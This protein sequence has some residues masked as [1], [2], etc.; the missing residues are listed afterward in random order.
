MYSV[1][2]PFRQHDRQLDAYLI[3]DSD[4]QVWPHGTDAVAVRSGP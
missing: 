4:E 1:F 2:A 3:S